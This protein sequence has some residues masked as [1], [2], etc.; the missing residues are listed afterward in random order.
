MFNRALFQVEDFHTPHT[1]GVGQGDVSV[2]SEVS[3]LCGVQHPDLLWIERWRNSIHVAI[4]LQVGC[5]FLRAAGF[6]SDECENI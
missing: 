5:V 3:T 1:I 4:R 2:F 6:T